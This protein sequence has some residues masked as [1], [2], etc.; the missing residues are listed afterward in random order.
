MDELGGQVG[1]DGVDSGK[2]IQGVRDGFD[3]GVA[4]EGDG[5]GGLA[6]VEVV[7]GSRGWRVEVYGLERVRGLSCPSW[8]GLR[9]SI[10]QMRL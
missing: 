7:S 1:S 4:V 10:A 3:A 2:A 8:L 5:E 6:V 9:A